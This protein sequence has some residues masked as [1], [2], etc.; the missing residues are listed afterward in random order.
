M[1]NTSDAGDS[2]NLSIADGFKY[3]ASRFTVVDKVTVYRHRSLFSSE[4]CVRSW[5]LILLNT[6]SDANNIGYE[7]RSHQKQFKKKE[8]LCSL[9]F[10]VTMQSDKIKPVRSI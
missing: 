4:V 9:S 6:I 5:V 1:E 8:N 2:C 3:G 10:Y 7:P